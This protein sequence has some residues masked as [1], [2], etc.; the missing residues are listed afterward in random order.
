MLTENEASVLSGISSSLSFS[1]FLILNFYDSLTFPFFFVT[2]TFQH[3]FYSLSILSIFLAVIK[4]YL[5]A[6]L[7]KQK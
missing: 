7:N 6:R 5:L 2:K 3:I 4:Y 1:F